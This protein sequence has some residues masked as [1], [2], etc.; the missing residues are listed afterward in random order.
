MGAPDHSERYSTV[1]L[2][3]CL[4]QNFPNPF[5]DKT[6]IK[7]CVPYTTRVRLTVYDRA[8]ETVVQLLDTQNRAGTYQVVF[9]PESRKAQIP[10]GAYTYRFE[11]GDFVE[12]KEMERTGCPSGRAP[13]VQGTGAGSGRPRI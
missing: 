5:S 11:A 7:Y 1:P 3:F 6:I 12:E 8:G 13:G 9:D 4:S 10:A 2:R